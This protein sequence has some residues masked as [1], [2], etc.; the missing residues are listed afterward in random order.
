MIWTWEDL[1]DDTTR[2]NWCNAVLEDGAKKVDGKR[3]RGKWKSRLILR[4]NSTSVRRVDHLVPF[5]LKITAHMFNFHKL[6]DNKKRDRKM[7]LSKLREFMSVHE[8]A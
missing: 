6:Y 5:A 4:F 7:K 1:R 2:D 3:M 8:F